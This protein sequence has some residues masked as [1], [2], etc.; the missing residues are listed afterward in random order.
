M[1]RNYITYSQQKTN[2]MINIKKITA[3]ELKTLSLNDLVAICKSLDNGNGNWS[4]VTPDEYDYIL[5]TATK[6]VNE[7]QN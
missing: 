5:E 2:P 4:D 7:Y 1:K 6:F 3:A